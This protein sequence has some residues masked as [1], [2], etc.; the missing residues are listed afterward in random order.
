MSEAGTPEHD[1]EQK[2]NAEADRTEMV[3]IQV[4]LFGTR[5]NG[6]GMIFGIFMLSFPIA[7]PTIMS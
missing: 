3:Y 7:F 4:L 2:I 5:M 1:P 6:T